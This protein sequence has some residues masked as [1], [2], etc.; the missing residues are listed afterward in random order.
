MNILSHSIALKPTP[1]QEEYFMKACGTSRM[2]WNWAVAEWDRLYAI[3]ERTSGMS[4]SKQFN[5]VKYQLFPWLKDMHRDSHSQPFIYLQTTYQRFFNDIKKGYRIAPDCKKQRKALHEQGIKLA[6]KPRFKKKGQCVDSF[7]VANDKIKLNDKIV[8][9]PR[10]GKV[11]MTESLRFAG[12]IMGAVV[13]RKGLHWFLVVKVDVPDEVFFCKRKR[14][15]VIGVDLGIKDLA[16]CSNGEVIPASRPLKQSLRRLKIRSRDLSRKLT[17]A[18]E[19]LGIAKNKPIP[20][21]TKLPVS[22]NR[23][24]AQRR[25]TAIHERIANKRKDV[26]DKL[27][28]ML[29]RE[30]QTV[31]MEDLNVKGMVKNRKLAQAI[32]DVGFGMIKRMMEYKAKRYRTKLIFA[33]QWYPSSKLCSSCGVKNNELTLSD[34][35][36]TCSSCGSEHDRDLN[37]ALNLLLLA[38][39]SPCGDKTALPVANI[40]VTEYTT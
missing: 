10:L 33:D 13:K 6:Y 26:A 22:N 12:K 28:T 2:V 29:C 9:L 19:S 1:E 24:K 20:K 23:N 11:L 38:T 31:V 14:H 34:R 4:L 17:A 27:T 30:N 7:Y 21:G 37:A 3:G 5:A 32:H 16:I 36:W 40:L 35:S 25:L 8:T 15:D 18:K 39:E